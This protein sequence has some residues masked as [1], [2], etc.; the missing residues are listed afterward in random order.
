M[1]ILSWCVHFPRRRFPLY[2]KEMM[3]CQSWI[4][5][6]HETHYKQNSPGLLT[7]TVIEKHWTDW[8]ALEGNNAVKHSISTLTWSIFTPTCCTTQTNLQVLFVKI[9]SWANDDKYDL[10]CLPRGFSVDVSVATLHSS[11]TGDL[12]ARPDNTLHR[13]CIKVKKTPFSASGE[14]TLNV[15]AVVTNC[16]GYFR[17]SSD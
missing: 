3:G 14:R 5:P 1:R 7:S 13:C 8:F 2:R 4:K 10:W 6:L 16:I 15:I 12:A 11:F 9:S 17:S